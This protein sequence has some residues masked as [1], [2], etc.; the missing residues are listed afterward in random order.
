MNEEKF[1]AIANEVLNPEEFSVLDYLDNLT[2]ANDTVSIYTDLAG[3]R[4]LARLMEERALEVEQIRKARATAKKADIESLSIAETNDDDEDTQYDEAINALVAQLE[5]TK[6]TFHLKSVAP[7]LVRAIN[8][9][10]D[11]KKGS[12]LTEEEDNKYEDRRTSDILSRAIEYVT[13]GDKGA[14]DRRPWDAERLS[15]LEERLYKEQSA[16]LLTG[17]YDMVFAGEYFE[18][19]I[20]ADF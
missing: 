15:A 14:E 11:A 9:S 13:L 18:R 5:K 3:S 6:L 17:L 20:T 1:E 19:A 12:D 2:V 10:Y 8:K 16:R 4:E 7:A